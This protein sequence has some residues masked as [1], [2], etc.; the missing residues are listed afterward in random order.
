MVFGRRYVVIPKTK[1]ACQKLWDE[2]S[3]RKKAKGYLTVAGNTDLYAVGDHFT[4]TFHRH[5]IVKYYDGYK[6]VDACGYSGSPTTQGRIT[7][8]TGAYM[9][10]NTSLGYEQSVRINGYPYFDGIRID[11]YGHVLEE[12]RRPDFKEVNKK[13]VVSAYTTL[14]RR[15]EKLIAGRYDLGEWKETPY[16]STSAQWDALMHLEGE[17][18]AG[19]SFL[20]TEQ[21]FILLGSNTHLRDLHARLSGIKDDLRRQYYTHNDG[22]ERI[23]VTQ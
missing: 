22:I 20:S 4:L 23:E 2:A 8:A 6:V 7:S 11:N 15:I 18:A 12:D 16:Q 9:A 5:D 3:T 1:A 17:I 10:S 19:E 21:V 14:F 13:P